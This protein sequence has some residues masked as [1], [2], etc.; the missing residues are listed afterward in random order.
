MSGEMAAGWPLH[1]A[2]KVGHGG[3]RNFGTAVAHKMGSFSSKEAVTAFW[4]GT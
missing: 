4:V 3:A 2:E 1:L